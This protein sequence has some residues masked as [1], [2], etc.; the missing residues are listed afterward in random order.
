MSGAA[1]LSFSDGSIDYRT[2]PG[3]SARL[4]S[5][6]GDHLPHVSYATAEFGGDVS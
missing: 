5:G 6:A 4:L 3:G 2:S 1:T